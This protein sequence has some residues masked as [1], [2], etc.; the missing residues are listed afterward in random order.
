[1]NTFLSSVA[2]LVSVIALGGT[3]FALVQMFQLQQSFR[4]LS[5]SVQNSLI[6]SEPPQSPQTAS[7]P[8]VP[9]TESSQQANTEIQ[10]GQFV[11][12]AFK[13]RAQVELLSVKRIQNPDNGQRNV[14]NVQM[15]VRNLGGRNGTIVPK[16]TIARNPET[17]ERYE[18]YDRVVDK[19]SFEQALRDGTEIDRSGRIDRATTYISLGLV[20]KGSSADGYVWLLIPEE[21]QTIDLIVPETA[22][23]EKVPI[24][25]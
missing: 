17:S 19:A 21:V 1:M 9:M 22:I 7:S 13:N 25:E 15:R 4:E 2:V 14:V 18:S 23:F 3:G 10:P 20:K 8:T 5:T 11:Q 24:S 6:A 16:L 12:Y